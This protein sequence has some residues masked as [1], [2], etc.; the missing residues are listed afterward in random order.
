MFLSYSFKHY[1]GFYEIK[2]V[3]RYHY[4]VSVESKGLVE[5]KVLLKKNSLL[6]KMLL[7]NLFCHIMCV[8]DVLYL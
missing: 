7:Q 3:I 1:L 4:S 8:F 5:V 2:C 6:V